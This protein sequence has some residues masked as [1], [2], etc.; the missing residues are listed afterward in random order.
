MSFDYY[1]LQALDMVVQEASFQRAADRLFVTQSAISQRIRALEDSVGQ[2]LLVRTNPPTLT[3]LGQKYVSTF[4]QIKTL[5]KSL[6]GNQ[7]SD[8][9]RLSVASNMECFDIWFNQCL[10]KISKEINVLFDVHLEDQDRTLELLKNAKV[11]GCVS[12]QRSPIQGCLSHPLRE[13]IYICVAHRDF[14]K[15]HGLNAKA[16]KKEK[17]LQHPTT[18]YG[19][20]DLIHDN[21][22]KEI[23]KTKRVPPYLAHRV[24]SVSGMLQYID[25]KAAFAVMPIELVQNKINSGEFVNLF[26]NHQMQTQLFWH[27]VQTE[28]PILKKLTKEVLRASGKN[29]SCKNS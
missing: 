12:S 23:L 20:F 3:D 25:E 6:E 2:P 29:E 15:K 16:F 14:V 8:Q 24:P 22:L 7:Q 26:P 10:I 17:L 4:R 1:Q 9:V 21:F 13:Q 28:I 18:I 27:V 5:M 19:P 11:L